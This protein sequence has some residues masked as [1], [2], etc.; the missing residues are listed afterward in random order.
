MSAGEGVSAAAAGE[1]EEPWMPQRAQNTVSPSM[2]NTRIPTMPT[3]D[4]WVRC[5][6]VTFNER[7]S[8]CAA[9]LDVRCV[10]THGPARPEEVPT[11]AVSGKLTNV[12]RLVDAV[13]DAKVV[14]AL[15]PFG[16]QCRGRRGGQRCRLAKGTRRAA[17][18]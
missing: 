1:E 9:V 10:W 16:S 3:W 4:W 7:A 15:R 14:L 12:G 17:S 6:G 5:D 2:W 11:V 18:V 13:D 8:W